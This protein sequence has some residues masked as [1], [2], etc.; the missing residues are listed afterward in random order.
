[1][2]QVCQKCGLPE[3]LCVCEEIARE[4]QTKKTTKGIAEWLLEKRKKYEDDFEYCEECAQ[5]HY[6]GCHIEKEKLNDR[7]INQKRNVQRMSN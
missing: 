3:K 6:L 7:R 2:N 4:Y 5:H 1:M